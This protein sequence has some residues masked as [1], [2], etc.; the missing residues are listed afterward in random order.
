M[1]K[2]RKDTMQRDNQAFFKV[3]NGML[4]CKL[5]SGDKQVNLN[6]KDAKD[7]LKQIDSEEFET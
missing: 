5:V 1:R 3:E 2:L 6:R 4:R 7:F